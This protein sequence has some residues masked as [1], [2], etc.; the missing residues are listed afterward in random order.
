MNGLQMIETLKA[1][2]GEA[3]FFAR[4]A[5]YQAKVV[6]AEQDLQRARPDRSARCRRSCRPLTTA[7]VL[8]LGGLQVMDGELTIGMLVAFQTLIGSFT[9][10]LAS[11]VNFGGDA[12]GARRAT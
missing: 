9:R 5:G 8:V 6:N 1:T 7:A 10:P 2:G 3:E 4:W 12:A 11:F